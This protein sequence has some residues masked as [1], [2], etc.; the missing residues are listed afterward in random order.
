VVAANP[1]AVPGKLFPGCR[2]ITAPGTD[3]LIPLRVPDLVA[4][5]ITE[6]VR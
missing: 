4:E 1:V 3:H 6:Q 2:R 5:V